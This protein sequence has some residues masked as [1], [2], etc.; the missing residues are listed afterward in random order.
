[1]FRANFWLDTLQS[2]LPAQS[3]HLALS[4]LNGFDPDDFH[5]LQLSGVYRWPVTPHPLF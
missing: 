3:W 4:V 2:G 1:M 5:T